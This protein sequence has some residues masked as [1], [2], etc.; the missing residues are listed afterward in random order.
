MYLNIVNMSLFLPDGPYSYRKKC[1]KALECSLSDNITKPYIVHL[2][3]WFWK[4]VFQKSWNQHWNPTI[5]NFHDQAVKELLPPLLSTA[6]FFF[7]EIKR[8]RKLKK[9][10]RSCATPSATNLMNYIFSSKLSSEEKEWQ[11]LDKW[12]LFFSF[13]TSLFFYLQFC[14]VSE[15]IIS[16]DLGFMPCFHP[17]LQTY[18]ILFAKVWV[19]RKIEKKH[20]VIDANMK[21]CSNN[22]K[23]DIYSSSFY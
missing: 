18:G 22:H 5:F 7:N 11:K 16:E 10:K 21:S 3:H 20:H 17:V 13:A 6:G 1:G 2:E 9:S 8:S 14:N 12:L 19:K 15:T 4:T 23:E